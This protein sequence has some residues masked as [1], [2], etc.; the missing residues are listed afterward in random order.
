M[1]EIAFESV[2][3]WYRD[4]LDSRSK[5]YT[6]GIS[7]LISKIATPLQSFQNSIQDFLNIASEDEN[8]LSRTAAERL[9]NEFTQQIGLIVEPSEPFTFSRVDEYIK[10][11]SRFLKETTLIARK[12]V[13]KLTR[14]YR[15]VVRIT[16]AYIK[17]VNKQAVAL[18]KFQTGFS[19][20]GKAENVFGQIDSIEESLAKQLEIEKDLSL[21]RNELDQEIE[22]A[23]KIQSDMRA[24]KEEESV[25]QFLSV[26][27]D[28]EELKR[29]AND[30]LDILS[31]PL[32]KLTRDGKY[33]F[34]GTHGSLLYDLVSSPL[35]FLYREDTHIKTVK[36]A[37]ESFAKALDSVEINY[38]KPK[39][40]RVVKRI[41]KITT[42]NELEEIQVQARKLLSEKQSL[43]GKVE[44]NTED[45]LR[46]ELEK[47]E[48]NLQYVKERLEKVELDKQRL[49]E[50][51][52]NLRKKLNRD[53]Y[54]AINEKVNVTFK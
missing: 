19:W 43:E 42:S 34:P 9:T 24:F 15:N 14:D 50:R 12:Y 18:Y 45:E 6:I 4:Q 23:Q 32:E 36:A 1:L 48:K 13:P 10:S 7:T 3:D 29:R 40:R 52:T 26:E 41:N 17:N 21:I 25:S 35:K 31:K 44:F 49:S 46:G 51:I 11:L 30:N 27:S 22:K 2:R 5:T 37:L 38:P 47:I 33:V 20:L 53:I 39:L 16:D 54:K 8:P 28:L